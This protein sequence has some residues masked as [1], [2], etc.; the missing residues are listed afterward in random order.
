MLT[1][2]IMLIVDGMY[3]HA[4]FF[5]RQAAAASGVALAEEVVRAATGASSAADEGQRL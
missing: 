3:A 5:G 2:R 1:D 4:A